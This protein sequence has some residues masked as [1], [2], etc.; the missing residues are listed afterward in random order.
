MNTNKKLYKMKSTLHLYNDGHSFESVFGKGGLGY[1]PM[2]MRGSGKYDMMP[3]RKNK[4]GRRDYENIQAMLSGL[5]EEEEK[6][7]IEELTRLALEYEQDELDEEERLRNIEEQVKFNR[8]F[9]MKAKVFEALHKNKA[10]EQNKAIEQAVKAQ[11]LI[12]EANMLERSEIEKAVRAQEQIDRLASI[13][14]IHDTS[15]PEPPMTEAEQRA[16]KK[17]IAQSFSFDPYEVYDPDEDDDDDTDVD[18]FL[19]IPTKRK[20]SDIKKIPDEGIYINLSPEINKILKDFNKLSPLEQIKQAPNFLINKI[21]GYNATHNED[22]DEEYE[23]KDKYKKIKSSEL[24]IIMD[25]FQNKLKSENKTE[26]EIIQ[27]MI[28]EFGL[29]GLNNYL[30]SLSDSHQVKTKKD[31]KAITETIKNVDIDINDL[32]ISIDKIN[33]KELSDEFNRITSTN[34]I[35]YKKI[36]ESDIDESLAYSDQSVSYDQALDYIRSVKIGDKEL[37]KYVIPKVEKYNKEHPGEKPKTPIT[38]LLGSGGMVF[39]NGLGGP[40]NIGAIG[41]FDNPDINFSVSDYVLDDIW[42]SYAKPEILKWNTAHPNKKPIDT[43]TGASSDKCCLD[44]LDSKNKIAVEL[45]DYAGVATYDFLEGYNANLV[46]MEDYKNDLIKALVLSSTKMKLADSQDKKDKLKNKINDIKEILKS[47]ESFELSFLANNKYFGFGITLNKFNPIPH[48]NDFS[49]NS[50]HVIDVASRNQSHQVYT[51]KMKNRQLIGIQATIG[52]D[53]DSLKNQLMSEGIRQKLFNKNQRYDYIIDARFP[54]GI[55][56]Y[57]YTKDSLVKNDNISGVYKI[58][59]NDIVKE[60][61]Y[62]MSFVLIPFHRMILKK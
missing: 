23:M 59:T 3:S 25:K 39:E 57:N 15:T 38:Y 27:A 31:K 35:P 51:P 33:D 50:K 58:I 28:D 7:E 18:L 2:R 24:K 54:R 42:E 52:D 53:K 62:K 19:D 4:E 45:K 22:L 46:M 49:I 43:I 11:E 48:V 56:E 60:G 37:L 5:D 55:A 30:I 1:H 9:D 34:Y 16:H 10:H 17:F 36:T 61:K 20:S 41:L 29:D 21:K 8:H 13:N 32:K 47:P 26:E 6:E 40:D 12:D 14:R 44:L